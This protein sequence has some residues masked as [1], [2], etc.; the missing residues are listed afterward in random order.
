MCASVW[1]VCETQISTLL[2]ACRT[3][4]IVILEY[5]PEKNVFEV[6]HKETFGKSGCRRIVPGAYLA[7][8]PKGRALLIGYAASSP[9]SLA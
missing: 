2:L 4:R 3:G 7:A 6:V 1:L 9:Y 5:Q 8:D